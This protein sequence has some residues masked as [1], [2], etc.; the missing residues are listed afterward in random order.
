MDRAFVFSLGW[1]LGE[2]MNDSAQSMPQL[3]GQA[4]N[5]IRG[6]M[7]QKKSGIGQPV[8]D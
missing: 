1:M 8:L 4:A 3:H 6:N 7:D 5:F 2:L